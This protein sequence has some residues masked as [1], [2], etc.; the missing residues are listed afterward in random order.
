MRRTIALPIITAVCAAFGIAIAA[1][2][3][4][5]DPCIGNWTI[6]VGGA[7]IGIFNPGFTGETSAYMGADQPVGY[8][9]FDPMSG[10]HELDRLFWYHRATCPA[11]YIEIVGHSEGAAII[12]AWISAHPD[13]PNASAVLIADPKRPAGPGGA[14]LSSIPGNGIIGYPL[15]GADANFGSWPVLE[16]CHSD[17]IVCN[18]P[19]GWDGYLFHSSHTDYDFSASDYPVNASGVWF[20]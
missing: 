2:Q 1:P 14:G 6:G 5:A 3:A 11:D 16:V 7:T 15:A 13:M 19:A 20:E 9:S 4:A 18:L 17:D 8:N 10:Y 12:H